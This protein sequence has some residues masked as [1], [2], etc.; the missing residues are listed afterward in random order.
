MLVGQVLAELHG[1]VP[2]DEPA[3][4]AALPGVPGDRQRECPGHGP[5]DWQTVG[6]F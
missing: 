3:R 2:E 5:K 4:L 6:G 1:E